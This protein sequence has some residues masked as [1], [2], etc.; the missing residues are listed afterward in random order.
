MID[1]KPITAE[2]YDEMMNIMPPAVFDRY[3]FLVG[4]PW[5]HVKC[6]VTGREVRLIF[7]QKENIT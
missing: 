5:D 6:S 4:E 3:S 1:F 7:R 2:R